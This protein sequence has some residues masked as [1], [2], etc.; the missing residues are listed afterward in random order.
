MMRD[1]RL[2]A[3]ALFLLLCRVPAASAEPPA[4]VGAT[5][6]FT[7][8]AP[9]RKAPLAAV[10][11]E[12]GKT[13]DLA[14]TLKGKVVVLNFWATWC[15]PCIVELPTLDK[16]QAEL[17]SDKFQVVVVSV[18]LKGMDVVG[19]FWAD[20]GY[21]NLAIRLDRRGKMMRDF[22]TRGLPTTF[23]IDREGNLVGYLEGHA[24]WASPAAK[25][26]VKYYVDRPM[27]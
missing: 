7:L 8:I 17:G 9:A 13:I 25:A 18:D 1:S 2:L 19:P 22:V 21:K 14:A 23:L 10:E 4:F 11:N 20:K 24:D 15:A 26:L 16:L 6:Q 5:G 3:T 12:A 27:R